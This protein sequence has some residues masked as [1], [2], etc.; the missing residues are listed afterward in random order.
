MSMEFSAWFLPYQASNP[1]TSIPTPIRALRSP[2]QH[3]PAG[4]DAHRRNRAH[5]QDDQDQCSRPRLLVPI[6]IRRNSI[7]ENLQRQRRGWLIQFQVPKLISESGE[8]QRGGFSRNASESQHT[9][10]NHASRGGTQ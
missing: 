4:D 5:D 2:L 9:S 6:V 10:G 7:S 1:R 3:S 8:Q